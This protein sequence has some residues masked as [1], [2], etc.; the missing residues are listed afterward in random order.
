MSNSIHLDKQLLTLK[1]SLVQTSLKKKQAKILGCIAQ[2]CKT[3]LKKSRLASF[4][5]HK[6]LIQKVLKIQ[7]VFR[8]Y[9][10]RSKLD[11][12]RLT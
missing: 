11:A 10:A 6:L 1:N 3:S 5:R 12:V 7:K 8:G 9:L 4:E 2:K